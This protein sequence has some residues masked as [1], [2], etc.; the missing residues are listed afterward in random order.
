MGR[1][2]GIQLSRIGLLV[3]AKL[4]QVYYYM[5]E[6]LVYTYNEVDKLFSVISNTAEYPYNHWFTYDGCL[7]YFSNDS[8]TIR[9]VDPSQAYTDEWDTPTDIYVSGYEFVYV[10]YNNN[11][12]TTVYNDSLGVYQFGY[13]Y[14]I[15]KSA[16]AAPI[17][18]GTYVL[19]ATVLNGKVTYSWV[20]D[21]VAQALQ[22]TNQILE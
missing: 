12:W 18:D 6:N 17:Q 14:G 7:Y 2:F 19:K 13:T 22:I 15:T 9:K 1:G 3:C 8:N 21:E 4:G 11:L 5:S 16:P 10:E 20:V